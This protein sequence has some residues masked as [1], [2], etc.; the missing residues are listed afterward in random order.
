MLGK[1]GHYVEER[2][3]KLPADPAT[4]MAVIVGANTALT[5]RMAEALFGRQMTNEDF[6]VLTMAMSHNAQ[7]TG[8]TDYVAAQLDAF[9]IAR[10]LAEFF[11]TCDVFL[12]PTLCA[13]PVKIGELDT[14]SNDLSNIAPHLR[15]YIPATSMFNMSGQPAMSVPLA[16][17]KAGLPLGMMFSARFGDEATLFRLAGQLEQARPWKDKLPPV[18]A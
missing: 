11:E 5:V 7:K 15:R 9:R 12:C 1:L 3:P 10:A 6:E 17:N 18:C 13:P 8:A 4:V 2:A 16:W 14:M